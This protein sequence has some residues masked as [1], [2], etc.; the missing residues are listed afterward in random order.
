MPNLTLP[1]RQLIRENIATMLTFAFSRQPLE[2][3]YES[4]F[5][6]EWDKLKDTLFNITQHRAERACL[7]LALLLRY[8]DDEEKLAEYVEKRTNFTFGRLVLPDNSETELTLRDVANKI[9]HAKSFEWVES[10]HTHYP[11]LVCHSREGEKWARAEVE[12]VNLA[13]VCGNLAN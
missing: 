10:Q 7:E 9:I 8:M 11:M 3:L 13:A 4:M 2:K 5:V 1:A 12:L 6:G